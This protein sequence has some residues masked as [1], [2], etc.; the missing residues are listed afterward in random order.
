MANLISQIQA[1]FRP[2]AVNC[3]F[4]AVGSV[5]LPFQQC[6]FL[7]PF[8]QIRIQFDAGQE[9]CNVVSDR[10]RIGLI[11]IHR[12]IR[13]GVEKEQAGNRTLFQSLHIHIA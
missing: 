9:E 13:H 5:G 11:S 12:N 2:V 1:F 4:V 8:T 6:V 10:I 7:V 3:H